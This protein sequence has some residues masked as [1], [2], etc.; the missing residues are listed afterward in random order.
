[1][2]LRSDPQ[3]EIELVDDTFAD[4][5]ISQPLDWT[6]VENDRGRLLVRVWGEDGGFR[7]ADDFLD[8]YHTA[9][10]SRGER[11]FVATARLPR[12]ELN[13]DIGRGAIRRARRR[14][15]KDEIYVKVQAEVEGLVCRWDRFGGGCRTRF[16][17]FQNERKSNVV[18]GLRF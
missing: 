11:E 5:T 2:L 8:L 17:Q 9:A 16:I 7:G 12:S 3:L 15:D 1:M 14:R 10:F 13:E 6:G 4:L 18:G